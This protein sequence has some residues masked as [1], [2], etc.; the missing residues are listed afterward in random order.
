MTKLEE[1]NERKKLTKLYVKQPVKY[2]EKV[3]GIETLEE[4]QKRVIETVSQN[5]R[6]C[7]SACHDVGKSFIMARIAI[8]FLTLH[9]NSKVITTAPTH[10]QVEKILWSEI[11][12]AKSKATI[13]LGGKLNTMD[14]TINPE[15]FAL[16][17]SPKTEAGGGDGQG[18]QSSFQGFHAPHVLVIFDEATGIPPNTWTM[19][20]GLLTSAH[21]KFVAIGNP[22]SSSSEFARCFKS[23]AWS[24][25]YLSCFDSPNLIANGITSK[26]IL[27]DEIERV[28]EMNDNDARKYLDNYKVTRPYLLTTKWVVEQARKWGMEHPLTVSKILGKFPVAGDNTL[29][30]LGFV[31]SA[32]LRVFYPSS[33]DRKTIG[34]DV[35]RF[36]T[37][38]TVLTSLHGAKQLGRKELFKHGTIEVT[39]EVI[40]LSKEIGGADIIVVDETGVGGGV[41]DL[42]KDAVSNGSLPKRCEIRG[43]QF[44]AAC[45]RDEDKEKYVNIKARMFGLLADDLKNE[46][47][48]IVLL[49]EAVY[50]DELPSILYRYNQKG[51][52]VI[53]SKDEYKK[54]TGR[55]SPDSADSLALANFGRYDDLR[56]GH[57]TK[58]FNAELARPLSSGLRNERNW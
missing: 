53:E 4:Y 22:T 37:D 51:Q 8:W 23:P 43:I 10:R 28:R 1:L 39:G 18:T 57:F 34:V 49:D 55:K 24:K 13:P 33:S 16:G 3:L 2:F 54:R 35:A 17:F 48:G 5:D 29:M 26:E 21:V 56:V 7:I 9:K 38:S 15:W 20:E 25:V 36:G 27:I 41:V 46:K 42:L 47:D 44:G 31:E 58:N 6:T 14:W 32:Q 45:E 40:N 30:P 11:A 19:A 12:A 50:L 52:M